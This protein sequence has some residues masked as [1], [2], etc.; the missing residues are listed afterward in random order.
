MNLSNMNEFAAGFCACIGFQELEQMLQLALDQS[1]NI[2]TGLPVLIQ[3]TGSC[4][5]REQVVVENFGESRCASRQ[6][7]T[8]ASDNLGVVISDVEKSTELMS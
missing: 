8:M 7:M 1:V 4:G 5:K 6:Q 2:S 3:H